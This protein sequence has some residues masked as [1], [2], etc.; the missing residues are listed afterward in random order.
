[1]RYSRS[2]MPLFRSMVFGAVLTGWI[3]LLPTPIVRAQSTAGTISGV[4]SDST[5]AVVP[6]AEVTV[7]NADTGLN[8][9][10][11]T[12]EQGRYVAPQLTLGSYEVTA[13]AQGF[14]TQI[15]T[16]ITLTVGQEA[17]V[18]LTLAVGAV[19]ERVEVTGEAPL[20]ETTSST[21]SGLVDEKTVGELP[22][23]GRS[24]TDLM[25]TQPLVK[26]LLA[27]TGTSRVLGFGLSFSVAGSHPLQN[28]YIVDGLF[29][30][31][32]RVA[33]PAS[34][35]GLVL[36]T[37]SIREFRM[38]TSNYSAEFGRVAG[39]VMT[40]VTK[41]GT[42]TLHGSAFEYIRNSDLDTPGFF[43]SG[44]PPPFKRNQ[45]GATVGGPIK[46]DRTFFFGSYEGLRQRLGT[47][48]FIQVPTLAAR[49]GLVPN[50]P[51]A[52]GC[53]VGPAAQRVLNIFPSPN[54]ADHGNGTADFITAPSNA[55]REDYFS[56]RLDHT[57]SEKHFMFGRYAFDD[58]RVDMPQA[59]GLYTDFLPNR[60]QY[61]VLNVTSLFSATLL[62]TFHA[63]VN[64]STSGQGFTA[65]APDVSP[66]VG[67]P[68]RAGGNIAIA[69]L[70]AIGTNSLSPGF[71]WWTSYQAGDDLTYS[72]GN[73][74]LRF[75]AGLQR[76]WDNQDA[77]AFY[78]GVWVFN[79]LPD[80]FAQRPA[81]L[82]VATPDANSERGWRTWIIGSYVQDD[83]KAR[84][85]LTLNLGL[86]F[87]WVTVP[88]EANNRIATLRN[89]FTDSAPVVGG[90][91]W[92]QR[93]AFAH[94]APRVGFAWDPFGNGKTSFRGGFGIFPVAIRNSDFAIPGDRQ[95]PFYVTTLLSNPPG[96]AP[97][98]YP[99]AFANFV[100]VG[101]PR[102]LPRAEVIDFHL[103]QPYKVNW[104][105][106][107]QREILPGTLFDVG[108]VGSRGIHLMAAM[109]DANQPKSVLS[110]SGRLYIP[111]GTPRPNP[112]FTQDRYRHAGNDSYFQ[113]LQIHLQKRFSHGFQLSSSYTWSKS[114]DTNSITFSQG[115]EF[116]AASS[117]ENAF[118]FNTKANRG[119]ASWDL[120]HYWST[121]YV[122]ELPVGPGKAVGGGL[123]G[124]GGK[125]LGGWSLAGVM[126]VNSGP[127]FSPALAIDYAGALPQTGGGGEKPDLAS[128]GKLNP[129]L[130][131][132]KKYFDPLAF[133]LPPLAPDCPGA[134]NCTRTVF[135]NVGRNT[136]VGP[137]LW[138]FDF[139]LL[140]D[141]KL[142]EKS[143][144]QFRAEFFNL[145]NRANFALPDNTIF[146]A[147]GQ[148]N[149]TA[150]RIAPTATAPGVVTPA[151]QIQFALKFI[152]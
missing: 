74:S 21:T 90:I 118:P 110:P 82:N 38:L 126:A 123:T 45:F 133:V 111:Q 134:T 149:P 78:S 119:P 130:G 59:S 85:G 138:T 148:R 1:M 60:Y 32:S 48:S 103:D 33:T 66:L 10:L 107:V 93:S 65:A 30:G 128:G 53:P 8:R 23:N 141:T 142:S 79:S 135:G 69:G 146:L 114:I 83:W 95:P 87:E 17:V 62:N 104:S 144:L 98:T 26:T 81:S 86:R 120:R 152:F 15:R 44:A 113:A 96:V 14:Q 34:A 20:V 139:S 73:H 122:Y 29:T 102:I 100:R 117:I 11:R 47:T 24:F 89:I 91:F 140:K 61:L 39:G 106:N 64:R 147:G 54:G 46:K 97:L 145:F 125:L 137:G 6:G 22:L 63:G 115:T 12:N 36:G 131:G 57:F 150:G 70:S 37:D 80:F 5:G 143:S 2:R 4:V 108:Y 51:C 31:D 42:N 88:T 35:S 94:L 77:R 7:K 132:P 92:E 18:N 3:F 109:S 68:G 50:G 116:A 101:Q 112:N 16:G 84:P 124:A 127:Y 41:S 52:S 121:N 71:Y 75:G 56:I 9:V 13:S 25:S 27:V 67:I 55:T 99:D 151:R 129:I 28:L 19:T 72:R 40:A 43:D 76:S 49:R 58:G 136:I 105:F